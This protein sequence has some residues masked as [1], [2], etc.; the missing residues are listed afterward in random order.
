MAGYSQF[1]TQHERS[2][3]FKIQDL[4]SDFGNPSFLEFIPLIFN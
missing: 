2:I 4:H 1:D 3:P